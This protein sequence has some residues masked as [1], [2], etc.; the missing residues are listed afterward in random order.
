M[1]NHHTTEALVKGV[2]FVMVPTRDF[3]RAVEFYGTVLGLPETA[4]YGTHPGVEFETGNLTIAVMEVEAFGMEFTVS[5]SPIALRVDDVARARS[6]LET[7]GVEFAGE[8]DSGVCWQAFFRDPDGN[9][10]ILH[11]RYAP[12]AG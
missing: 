7:R 11:H 3:D 8:V 6:E 12:K 1:S 4:R 10:L 2:D 5:G 9:P